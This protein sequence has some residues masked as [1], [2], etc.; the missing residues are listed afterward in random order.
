MCN[1]TVFRLIVINFRVCCE[2]QGW[3]EW[4]TGASVFTILFMRGRVET[5]T[6]LCGNGWGWIQVLAG[7]G[8]DGF[9]LHGDG[10]GWD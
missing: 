7:A 10:W 8:G 4:I 5:E 3:Y 2:F 9:K 6:D 1:H